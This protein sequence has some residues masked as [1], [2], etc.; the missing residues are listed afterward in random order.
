[1]NNS[2]IVRG[3][4]DKKSWISRYS[5]FVG[6]I[7]GVPINIHFSFAL[8]FTLIAWTL[9]YTFFPVY[10]PGLSQFSYIV[11]GVTGASIALFSIMFHELGHSTIA[12]KYGIKFEKIVLFAF[13]GIA[14]SSHEMTDPKK[15]ISMAFAGPSVSFIISSLSFAL[16]LIAF[17][18]RIF[19]LEDSPMGGILY[20]GGLINLAIGLFNLLPVF[21][22]DGGRILRA[23][24]S[25]YMHDHVKGT[26]AALRIGMI[27][28]VGLVVA[29]LII[30]LK[31]SFVSGLW[32]MILAFFLIRASQWYYRQY[33]D[34]S[35]SF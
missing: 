3:E 21:P 10:Y 25:M 26:K 8:I 27:I 22:S 14:L 2:E 9:S 23:F 16:W 6:K 30:C 29:G 33:E 34:L 7:G 13:G 28:S 35:S 19:A 1:M 24:L 20:Y 4:T 12:N 11:M 17:Q 32:L 15:E 5:I 31:Y 18:S